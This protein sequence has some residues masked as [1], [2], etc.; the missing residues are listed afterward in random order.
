MRTFNTLTTL[1]FATCML[2][3]SLAASIS[4]P[5]SADA[6][7]KSSVVHQL[8]IYTLNAANKDVFHE[9]FEK[10]AMPIMARY[11]FNIISTWESTFDG[12]TEFVYLLEWPDEATLKRQWAKFMADEEWQRIKKETGGKYG[13]FVEGIE[14]RTL[15]LTWYSPVKES[16]KSTR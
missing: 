9:R 6:A 7:P 13:S 3:A 14:D 16:K 8:R 10:Q 11:D 5:T 4:P 15:R 12:E 1:R 2:I